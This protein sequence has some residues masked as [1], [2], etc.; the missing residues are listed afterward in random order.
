LNVEKQRK[1]DGKIVRV[2]ESMLDMN[3]Q[4]LKGIIVDLNSR[5]G[6]NFLTE[7][8]TRKIVHEHLEGLLTSKPKK[9]EG[10]NVL[11]NELTLKPTARTFTGVV[12]L[13]DSLNIDLELKLHLMESI[14]KSKFKEES[15]AGEAVI[16]QGFETMCSDLELYSHSVRRYRDAVLTIQP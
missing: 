15:L 14:N 6:E 1:L 13:V 9:A 5:Y 16:Q 10:H 3:P 8:M 12:E 11:I 2:L 4:Y 7:Y